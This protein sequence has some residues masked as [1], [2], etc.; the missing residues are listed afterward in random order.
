MQTLVSELPV[1]ETQQAGVQERYGRAETSRAI[2][3]AAAKVFAQSGFFN[4]KVADV[5][6]GQVEVGD[7]EF[8]PQVGPYLRREH[9]FQI[10]RGDHEGRSVTGARSDGKR[11]G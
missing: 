4:A 3:R 10:N 7:A 9:A 5:A 11:R 8:L 1:N 6:R 2:L